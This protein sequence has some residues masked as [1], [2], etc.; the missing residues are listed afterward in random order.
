V[1][2]SGGKEP[3]V[4]SFDMQERRMAEAIIYL[5]NQRRSQNL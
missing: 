4:S 3:S 1:K 2:N 5:R